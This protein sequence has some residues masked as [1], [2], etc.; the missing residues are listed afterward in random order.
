MRGIKYFLLFF[1]GVGA[2]L[3]ILSFY[4]NKDKSA[5]IFSLTSPL[6]DALSNIFPNVLGVS[7][8]WYPSITPIEEVNPPRLSAVSAL[9]YDLSGNQTLY[10]HNEL[11]KVPIAS[12]TKIM[13]AILAIENDNLTSTYEISKDAASVGENAMGLE[14]GEKISLKELLY[15]MMLPSGNDAAEAIAEGSKFGRDGFVYQMNK[16]AEDLG[17]NNTRFTN[18]SGLEGDGEQY[19]TVID[20]LILSRYAMKNPQFAKIVGTYEHE[21]PETKD[22]KNYILKN[23]TNLLTSYPGVRGIKTGFTWEAGMC[24]VTYYEKDGV[25]IIAVILNSQDRR[26]EMKTLLDY[27]I[28]KLGKTPPEH[29]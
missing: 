22:H 19:S 4:T 18:P 25:T 1:V 9:A 29:S 3:L 28:R 23:D 17:L 27:S 11:K 15:G 10:S 2:A 7:E 6:P 8:H 24:L 21:I 13:T 5:H 14:A 20:L 12:L 16:K 26:G